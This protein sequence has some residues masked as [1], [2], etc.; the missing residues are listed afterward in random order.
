MPMHELTNLQFEISRAPE[1]C[2]AL[3]GEPQ[4]PVVVGKG[5]DQIELYSPV[6]NPVTTH[7]SCQLPIHEGGMKTKPYYQCRLLTLS[8]AC[9]T[10]AALHEV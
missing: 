4:R 5:G 10:V 9:E 7:W 6:S 8:P 1:S 2:A 3:V